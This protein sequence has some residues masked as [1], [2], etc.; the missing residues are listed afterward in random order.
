MIKVGRLCIKVAGRDAGLKCVIVDVIDDNF[1]TIDG[2]TRR[3]KCNI[4]HLEPLKDT[5]KLKPKADHK[6][7]ISEFKKLDI[8]TKEKKS[9]EKTEKPKKQKKVKKKKE[10]KTEK[11]ETKKPKEEK[12]TEEKK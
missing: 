9:R 7:V 3:R 8:E 11:K 1:V 5:I 12:K 2:Q 6:T 10:E 4:K